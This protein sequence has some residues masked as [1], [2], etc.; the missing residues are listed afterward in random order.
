MQI[1]RDKDLQSLNTLAVPSRVSH[2]C[3]VYSLDELT[4]ALRWAKEHALPVFILGGGSNVIL[5][6]AL[7][8]LLIQVKMNQIAVLQEDSD[9]VIVKV[10]AGVNWHALVEYCVAKHY[11]GLENLALI[12]GD[13]GAAPIQNIGAYGVELKDV[14]FQLEAI[15]VHTLECVQFAA[16][17]CEFSYRDS[18][19]KNRHSG[20]YIIYSV[21]LRLSKY[22]R[23]TIS[24][25]ALA[26]FFSAEKHLDPKKLM[27]GVMAI[28]QSKL[29]DP[30]EL[31]NVG[32]FFKNPVISEEQCKA[33]LERYPAMVHFPYEEL[34]ESKKM[35]LA[36][37]WLIDS[38]GWKGREVAG[39]KVHAQHALVLT[40]PARA[41]GEAVLTLAAAIRRSVLQHY[42]VELEIEPRLL[43]D[44]ALDSPSCSAS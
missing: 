6:E 10:D 13:V 25:P 4:A 24:Y 29:P 17:D 20:R 34:P 33:L 14:F 18:V 7:S 31:P 40:N 26:E 12:P 28:R 43:P 1:E 35:K 37:A 3:A 11:C 16:Q 22:F 36:A 5:G 38:L 32:S 27:R 19:F 42:G 2:Y 9:S 30:R 44:F 41:S 23:P 15:D 21:S 39:V 8:G